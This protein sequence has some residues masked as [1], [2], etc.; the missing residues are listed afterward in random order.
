MLVTTV[1]VVNTIIALCI[2]YAAIDPTGCRHTLERLGLWPLIER[3]EQHGMR[4]ILSFVGRLLMLAGL[5]LAVSVMLGHHSSAWLLPAG[6]SA[7][8]GL[9][10]WLV[11]VLGGKD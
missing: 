1:Y 4:R 9:I 3:M 7:F 5:L 6:E 8:F 10:S 2:A 11:A